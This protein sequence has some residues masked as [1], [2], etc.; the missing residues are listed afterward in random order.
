M[1][2]NCACNRVRAGRAR[3]PATS[4]A[5]ARCSSDLDP[6]FKA[7]DRTI[8]TRAGRARDPQAHRPMSD[9]DTLGSDN[10]LPA[11]AL[12]T[13]TVDRLELPLTEGEGRPTARSVA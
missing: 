12:Q 10:P 3:R 6:L 1:A 13:E 9:A 4:A 7:S 11:V 8:P 5:L 2:R